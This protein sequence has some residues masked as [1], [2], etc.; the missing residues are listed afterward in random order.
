MYQ[1]IPEA[2]TGL[3]T[4]T[5]QQIVQSQTDN[6][7]QEQLTNELERIVAEGTND[8]EDNDQSEYVIKPK[9]FTN[10]NDGLRKNGS[11]MQ[12][13]AIVNG[14]ANPKIN[15]TKISANT[16]PHNVNGSDG[17]GGNGC[18]T[19]LQTATNEYGHENYQAIDNTGNESNNEQTTDNTTGGQ[20]NNQGSNNITQHEQD[21]GNNKPRD[22]GSPHTTHSE[23]ELRN[24][25]ISLRKGQQPLITTPP[26]LE[27][28]QVNK[29]QY[30]ISPQGVPKREPTLTLLTTSHPSITRE[31]RQ[32][33][34]QLLKTSPENTPK[35]TRPVQDPRNRNK[36]STLKT[37]QKQSPTPR[38]TSRIS[39]T[40]QKGEQEGREGRNLENREI[41]LENREISDR[42]VR[43]N[44]EIL[45]TVG[46]YQYE[47]FHPVRIYPPIQRQSE[48]QRTRK[49]VKD[50][51]IQGNR[52]RSRRIQD[53]VRGRIE[54][55]HC[56][57]DQ[58]G[59]DQMIKPDI[60]DKESKR[61]M[62]KD[63]R[64]ES[65]EQIDSRLPLQD[66]RFEQGETNNQ[67]WGLGHF[68]GPL[69]R[70]SQP[71]SPNR[72]T[73]IP[74]IRIPEQ[75]LHIQSNAIRNQTLTN[76]LCNSYGT[77]NATNKNE[78]RDQNNQ[79]CRRH[80]S[81]SPDQGVSEEHDLE[82]NRHTEILRIHN[83]LRKERDRTEQNR[84]ISKMGME[85]SQ[86]NSQNETEEA[87]TSST[88][89]IQY[90]K[91]DKDGNRN[92]SKINSEINRK[93][94]LLKLQ[95]QEASLFLNTMDH[96]KAQAARLRGWNT[97][98]TMNKTAIPDINWWIAKLRANIPAQLI[99]IPSQMTMTT[100]EAPSSWGLTLE[101][102]LEM[103]AMAHGTQNKRQVKLLSNNREIKTITQGLRSFTK[104]L[105]ILRIQSLAIRSDNSTAVFDIG[106]W[107]ASISLIIEIKQVHYTTE[108]LGIQI[109]ITHLPGGKNE[110][111]DVLSRFLRAG[112]YKLK[113]KIFLQT[114]LQMNLNSTIDLFSQHFNN[115]LLRFMSSIRGLGEIAI[116]TLNQTWK[117]ELPWIHPR[118]PLL[119]AVLKKIRE[120][121]TEAM[122]IAPLWPGQIWYTELVN[123][124]A[125]SLM[126]GWS[127][128]ILEPGTSLIKK[129]LKLHPRKICS[130][131]M[132]RMSRRGEYSQE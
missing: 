69:L 112:D 117:M 100:D 87:I 83:E 32:M 44:S 23:Q 34:P 39:W 8:N 2:T 11:G 24:Q 67:T 80:P 45:G 93:T 113:E 102:Q 27:A 122:I 58:K 10:G 13:Q 72:I 94:K 81:P 82:S 77:N 125:E 121:Q 17:L 38:L 50:N 41:D 35:A 47:S 31:K 116:D 43:I 49:L 108:K 21:N 85:S 3:I 65:F 84:N 22:I 105:K 111:A 118:I 88:R 15:I 123:E 55:E 64:C 115:L 129:N 52:R 73:T 42:N 14:E 107:R 30:P 131:Q 5:V 86:C 12:L 91:M 28:K 20:Q 98:I 51:E 68:N 95:I 9:L 130:F 126:L 60:Y 54:R 6:E 119:P 53:N 92:N 26:E 70:I 120:E 29:S 101:R 78:N 124:Y 56:S 103:I 25:N 97:T 106:K 19:H 37:R 40:E 63:T 36:D 59:I 109:Q 61:E 90:E 48:D 1:S 74:S 110:I 99:Q 96:Q 76:I 104:I 16:P 89:S 18:E 127:I 7:D 46:N 62:E 75:L 128:E 132:D 66:A 114:C 4:F 33:Q 57:I 79:L 71:N